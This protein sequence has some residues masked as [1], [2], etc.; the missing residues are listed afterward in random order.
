MIEEPRPQ[1]RGFFIWSKRRDG[2]LS[3]MK[4]HR[5]ELD[6]IDPR[7]LLMAPLVLVTIFHIVVRALS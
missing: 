6:G 7:V 5:P 2:A 1:G 3:L 4:Q